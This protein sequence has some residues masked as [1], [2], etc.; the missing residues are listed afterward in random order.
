MENSKTKLKIKKRKY[1]LV[2]ES[3][4]VISTPGG[5]SQRPFVFCSHQS[6]FLLNSH[7][8][9]HGVLGTGKGTRETE[10]SVLELTSLFNWRISVKQKEPCVNNSDQPASCH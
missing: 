1:S 9:L 6:T 7:G 2:R 10:D 3:R 4:E 5:R 8:V